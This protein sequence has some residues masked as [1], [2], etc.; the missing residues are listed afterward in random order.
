MPKREERSLSSNE[1]D[2]LLLDLLRDELEKGITAETATIVALLLQRK[3]K[4]IARQEME[5]EGKKVRLFEV[6]ETEEML[7]V[8]LVNLSHTT[9]ETLQ[10]T[11]EEKLADYVVDPEEVRSSREKF[12]LPREEV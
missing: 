11:L 10:K 1:Q 4:L 6:I 5:V 8:P 12:A 7:A 3:R 2:L 9:S